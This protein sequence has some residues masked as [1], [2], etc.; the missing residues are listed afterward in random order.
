V[1]V[2]D[3]I[4]DRIARLEADTEVGPRERKIRLMGLRS[5]LAKY[6]AADGSES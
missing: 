6:S 2:A 3:E 4:R 1:S 5:L